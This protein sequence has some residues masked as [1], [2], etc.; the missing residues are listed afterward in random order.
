MVCVTGISL[1]VAVQSLIRTTST[2]ASL[3]RGICSRLDP[4]LLYML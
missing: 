2:C 3:N 4:N 1:P